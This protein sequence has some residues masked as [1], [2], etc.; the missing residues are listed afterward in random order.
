MPF[1]ETPFWA[2]STAKRKVHDHPL[3]P[4]KLP[5][6]LRIHGS[7][8]ARVWPQVLIIGI[9]SCGITCLSELGGHRV[10]LGIQTTMISTLGFIVGL[11]LSFRTSTAYANWKEARTQWDRVTT[12]ARNLSRIIWIHG[13]DDGTTDDLLRKKSAIST[14]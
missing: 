14:M 2:G 3:K 12:I 13:P 7:V 6:P 5:Y 10:N 1:T 8:I 9:F 4:N 11:A